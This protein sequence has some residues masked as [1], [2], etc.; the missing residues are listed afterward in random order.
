M[1]KVRDFDAELKA[2][3]DKQRTLKA[4]RV[5]QLGEL[6]LA[7]GAEALTVEQL[8]GA[9]F[10]AVEAKADAKEAWRRR[11][12]EFF[13]KGT[14]AGRGAARERGEAETGGLFAQLSAPQTR[15]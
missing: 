14:K 7:T 9:L 4:K 13:C 15:S 12:A 10:E 5:Q 11:G 6:V 3:A 2:L 8:A 1:R